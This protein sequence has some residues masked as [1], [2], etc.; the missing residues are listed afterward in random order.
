[1]LTLT[2]GSSCD[3]CAEEYG[4]HC[5][6]NSIP[7]GHVLCA[8]CCTTIAEKTAPK[9]SPACPFCREN[10]TPDSVRLIRLDFNTSGWTTPRRLPNMDTNP[11]DFA[12]D[13]WNKRLMM[14]DGCSRTRL[15]AR[16]LEAKVAKVA[17]KKCSVEEVTHLH[18]ELQEWLMSDPKDDD[19][20]RAQISSLT[21][22]AALLR[23]ILTNH[24][25]HS[26]SSRLAKN[27]E[28]NLKT[29]LDDLDL[30]NSKLD[31]ELKR[32]VDLSRTAY[33]QKAQECQSLRQEMSRMKIVP[34]TQPAPPPPT[35]S[36]EARHLSPSPPP[37][38]TTYTSSASSAA[39]F[40]STHT[41]SSS[42]F[43]RPTTPAPH[44]ARAQTPG[45][46]SPPRPYTPAPPRSQTPGPTRSNSISFASANAAA[47]LEK[48][49]TRAQTPV[50]PS[51]ANT[52]TP[53]PTRHVS[54]TAASTPLR[55][56][57]PAPV[58]TTAP[59]P[60][61]R[62]LSHPSPPPLAARS[63]SEEKYEAQALHQRWLPNTFDDKVKY[64]VRPPLSVGL[65]IPWLSSL[66]RGR[67][68]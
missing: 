41:R 39:R 38:P 52:T 20:S 33:S 64:M 11:P 14:A 47:R 30:M 5:L 17:A 9:L 35:S 3:V 55:S 44:L 67:R 57:T 68:R 26:E 21:L 40:N 23:A 58:Q 54:M 42:L 4:P 46:V 36:M 63:L 10:F 61:A 34:A 66:G 45:P 62:R 59:A 2:P 60:R 56:H 22:S 18:K 27:V 37:M 19:E 32:C 1:M 65:H 53:T 28:A 31:S 12:S 8:S 29:K 49:P 24:V 15:D 13:A 48:S 7:C 51:R 16:R 50:P 6:P 25:A 43:S